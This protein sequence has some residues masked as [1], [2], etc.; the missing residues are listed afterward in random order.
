MSRKNLVRHAICCARRLYYGHMDSCQFYGRNPLAVP[1]TSSATRFAR[2]H[3]LYMIMR[4]DWLRPRDRHWR[5]RASPLPGRWIAAARYTSWQLR[6]EA[7]F[8]RP[9]TTQAGVDSG[10]GSKPDRS[11]GRRTRS[12]DHPGVYGS[13]V[14]L[15]D[16]TSQLST[17]PLGGLAK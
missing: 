10:Y 15:R 1:R 2:S 9:L 14:R 4:V 16:F 17:P 6:P 7:A 12:S 11:A 5:C 8:H 3:E 13:L